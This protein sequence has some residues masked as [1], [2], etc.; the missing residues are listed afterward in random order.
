[1]EKLALQAKLFSKSFVEGEIAILSIHHH[2]VTQLGEVEPNLMHPSSIGLDFYERGL[3]KFLA[4][5]EAG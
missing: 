5:F 4:D 2:G 3:R 1:M